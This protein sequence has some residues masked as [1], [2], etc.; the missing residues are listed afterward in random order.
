MADD[1]DET[2]LPVS[3]KRT[4]NRLKTSQRRKS[5]GPKNKTSVTGSGLPSSK[6]TDRSHAATSEIEKS[7]SLTDL[8]SEELMH[9]A[10]VRKFHAPGL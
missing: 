6:R 8:P 7:S 4:A 3:V 10:Q 9:H 1:E 5:A 2:V